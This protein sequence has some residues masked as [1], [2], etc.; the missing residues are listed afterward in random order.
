MKLIRQ[1]LI[2]L[3]FC[4]IGELLNK[5][6]PLNIPTSIYGLLLMFSC[7]YFKIIKPHDVDKAANF[8]IEIM[9]ILFVPASVGIIEAVPLF[10][11][12]FLIIFIICII[13]TFLV[14]GITAKL[15]ECILLLTEKKD[16]K[17]DD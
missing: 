12:K 14:M 8:L 5:I 17:N 16:I 7:L 10:K 2:I 3:S 4:F 13:S 1:F 11:D 9:P 15:T 6:I